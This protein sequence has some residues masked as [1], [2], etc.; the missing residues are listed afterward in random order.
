M[1]WF[2]CPGAVS[3][4]LLVRSCTFCFLAPA[5]EVAAARD[6]SRWLFLLPIPSRETLI[7][8]SSWHSPSAHTLNATTALQTSAGLFALAPPN[9]CY[10][11]LPWKA[12]WG[13]YCSCLQLLS[14]NPSTSGATLTR[15][16][17]LKDFSV[18]F[19][20]SMWNANMKEERILTS[21]ELKKKS[22]HT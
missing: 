21:Q 14:L 6:V 3:R 7:G 19:H 8:L 20:I 16:K 13:Q 22:A 9:K 4:E 2:L 11:S 18:H 5:L 1:L 10:Q 12:L 15:G 17:A